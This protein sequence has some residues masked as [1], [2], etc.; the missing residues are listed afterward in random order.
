MVNG[1]TNFILSAMHQVGQ[2][3][4]DALADAQEA[5]YAEADPTADVEGI[6][7]ANK[8]VILARLAFGTWLDPDSVERAP[9]GGGPG[10][11]GVSAE[12]VEAAKAAG[13]VIKLVAQ[14]KHRKKRS[15]EDHGVAAAVCIAPKSW[16][17]TP[18]ALIR[19]FS[20]ALLS[21]SMY[22]FMCS[23]QPGFVRQCSS[24]MSM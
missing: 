16:H 21:T 24:T 13:K 20:F 7:A 15:G 4:E 22:G 17:D 11:T 9:Q 1:T 19:P 10:I 5:G 12:D 23:S 2:G 14:A 18:S 8:L 3:Y 6:D